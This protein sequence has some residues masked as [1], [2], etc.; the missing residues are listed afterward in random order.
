MVGNVLTPTHLA[1]VLVVALLV[2]GPKRLPAAGRGLGEAMRG[3]KDALTSDERTV[4][5]DPLIS[6]HRHIAEARD[7]APAHTARHAEPDAIALTEEA[8][9]SPRP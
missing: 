9:E 2:L 7:D 8:T 4:T 3:F 6:E 1:L 5:G